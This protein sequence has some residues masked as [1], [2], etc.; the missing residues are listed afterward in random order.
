M[1][2]PEWKEAM[3]QELRSHAVNETW[4]LV[5]LPPGKKD[6]GSRWGF[7]LKRDET[8]DVVK[9]RP[10]QGYRQRYGEDYQDDSAPF[11]AYLLQLTSSERSPVLPLVRKHPGNLYHSAV[12]S[13]TLG[14]ESRL[15]LHYVTSF[16]TLQLEDPA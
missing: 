13:V 16:I 15:V 2:C 11:H 3:H 9:H 5:Q 6:V 7:K 4:N 14:D 12:L 10:A 1:Q 8:G